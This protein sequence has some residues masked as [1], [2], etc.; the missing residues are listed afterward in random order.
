MGLASDK[1]VTDASPSRGCW[2]LHMSQKEQ[3]RDLQVSFNWSGVVH[4]G[5][6][7]LI[8]DSISP[9]PRPIVLTQRAPNCDFSFC[10]TQLSCFQPE[11]EVWFGV[12][13]A[14]EW[15][16]T[17]I[18]L[19]SLRVSETEGTCSPRGNTRDQ[20][21]IKANHFTLGFKVVNTLVRREKRKKKKEK[22]ST[23]Q[24]HP[25]QQNCPKKPF[26]PMET[27]WL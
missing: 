3:H 14:C 23:G 5:T 7:V 10:W 2:H 11:N 6:P 22:A 26:L 12:L 9:E 13:L 8:S 4:G 20:H 19:W 15:E 16:M 21:M 18:P 24:K 17:K 25:K 1:P 27:R